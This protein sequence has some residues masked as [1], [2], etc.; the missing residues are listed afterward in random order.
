MSLSSWR[1]FPFFDCLP[2]RDPYYGSS[3]ALYSDPTIS[4]ICASPTHLIIATKQSTVKLITPKYKLAYQFVA[5]ETGWTITKLKYVNIGNSKGFLCTVAERQGQPLSLKLWDLEKLMGSKTVD[6]NSD[7][8]T[9]C[10]VTNGNNNYPLTCFASSDDFSIL[11]FGFANGS[12]IL[13]RG[14]LLHD[15]GSR[16]RVVFESQEPIT[17]VQLRSE[18]I[19]FVSTVSRIFTIP[20]TG[21]NQ[22]Y[23]DKLLEEKL[24]ADINCVDILQDPK[25]NLVVARDESIQFYN[26]KG[27]S[28]NLM[29]D[30]PKKRL[31]AYK[32]KYI[33]LVSSVDSNL[34]S[35]STI[36]TNKLIIVDI[37]NN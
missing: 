31:H 14:D 15:R 4:G 3:D 18:S 10:Q 23:P 12:V 35:T 28:H 7:Y 13:V 37:V 21:R 17:D 2:I 32:S 24:G 26:S 11:A 36:S 29:L 8:H 30:I 34:T 19:L 22:G 6:F 27:K 9:L 33:L 5:Y 16:Q 20:T 25:K 1:Q